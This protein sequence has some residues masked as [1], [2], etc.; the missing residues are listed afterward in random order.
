MLLR[1][2]QRGNLSK[3]LLGAYAADV[4]RHPL[5]RMLLGHSDGLHRRWTTARS[6]A[7]FI[8]GVAVGNPASLPLRTI[9]IRHSSGHSYCVLQHTLAWQLHFALLTSPCLDW[10]PPLMSLWLSSELED[11]ACNRERL[12]HIGVQLHALLDRGTSSSSTWLLLEQQAVWCALLC[13]DLRC[14]SCAVAMTHYSALH[15]SQLQSAIA[16]HRPLDDETIRII[17]SEETGM[18][19][20]QSNNALRF[21]LLDVLA[22]PV[23]HRNAARIALATS[24]AEWLSLVCCD[25]EPCHSFRILAVHPHRDVTWHEPSALAMLVRPSMDLSRSMLAEATANA[26]IRWALPLVGHRC[27]AHPTNALTVGVWRIC[28]ADDGC[29]SETLPASQ[30]STQCSCS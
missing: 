7:C 24:T 28:M 2:E 22:Q 5:C 23:L 16:M 4:E 18:L 25:A 29:I 13:R 30:A 20:M 19:T 17:T 1:R 8:V 14:C 10:I 11:N 15:Q 12:H 27:G 26:G 6:S 3:R 21:V 9:V